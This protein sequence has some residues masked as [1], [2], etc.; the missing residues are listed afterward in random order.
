MSLE[1]DINEREWRQPD[2][3]HWLGIY[4]SASDTRALVPKRNP[5][6]GYTLNFAHRRSWAYLLGFSIV[7][8]GFVLLFI[9]LHVAR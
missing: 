5:R 8:L 4:R 3:W 9:L 2:N 6:L 1:D 7:P